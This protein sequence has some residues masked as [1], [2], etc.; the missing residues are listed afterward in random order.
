MIDFWHCEG[1]EYESVCCC[2]LATKLTQLL[3]T[4]ML[5]GLGPFCGFGGG[6][7]C[8]KNQMQKEVQEGL[9]IECSNSLTAS[10]P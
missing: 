6:K 4:W 5:T 3:Q 8:L 9:D 10:S 7:S 2:E 1:D